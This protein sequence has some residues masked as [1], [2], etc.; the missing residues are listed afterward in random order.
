MA[1]E[2]V[3]LDN[4]VLVSGLL[5]PRSV[6]GQAFQLALS[7]SDILVSEATLNELADVLS[8]KKFDRY[9]SV[10]DRQDF[11]RLL[12]R[13]AEVVPATYAIHA[14]M[15]PKDNM[16]LEVTVNGSADLLVTG[17]RDV[18]SMNPFQGVPIVMPSKYIRRKK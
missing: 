9:V 15:D 2:R 14:C 12:S 17:D 1:K 13:V 6:P 3:V 7:T 4:N 5:L 11:L 10:Q 16:L 18:L 8:R